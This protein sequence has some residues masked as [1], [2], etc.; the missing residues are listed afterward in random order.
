MSDVHLCIAQLNLAIGEVF[1]LAMIIIH[2]HI[3]LTRTV[4]LEYV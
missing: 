4:T 2:T 1:S 3:F